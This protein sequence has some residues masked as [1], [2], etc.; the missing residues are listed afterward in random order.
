MLDM[1]VIFLDKDKNKHRIP[2]TILDTSLG[3]RWAG[4][5][6][7]N[8]RFLS[9]KK[10]HSTF[11]NYTLK[12]LSHIVDTLN[13]ISKKINREYDRKLPSFHNSSSLNETILNALHEEFEFYGTRIDDLSQRPNF[14]ETLHNNFL[15]LNELIHITEDLIHSNNDE[16]RPIP[17]MSV[18]VDYYP[19]STFSEI[20][21]IDKLHLRTDFK[22]GGIYLG[23]N[24]LGKDWL[25]VAYDN[26]LE[27]IERDMIKPQSRFS[28]ETWINFGP[29]DW[30]NHNIVKFEQWYRT[31]P[32]ELQS[33]VPIGDLNTLSLG[34]FHIGHVEINDQ[35][36]L[37]YHDNISDWLSP[38]HPIKKKWNEEVF[39]TFRKIIKIGFYN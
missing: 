18:L 15:L 11:S 1:Y 4:L 12:D 13:T 35:Y 29:D 25:K 16:F 37:K 31:L 5:L 7:K 17:T 10:L 2:I 32:K 20:E 28:A 26:D 3:N 9:G 14:S 22:W 34:R 30:L 24:T 36:F 33:K 21:D 38:N 23:Y 19:Q 27:V 8:Q 6:I 39:S